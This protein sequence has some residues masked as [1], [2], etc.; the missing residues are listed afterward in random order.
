MRAL[1]GAGW[2]LG[3]ITCQAVLALP[4]PLPHPQPQSTSTPLQVPS[5]H[6]VQR[7]DAKDKKPYR[8]KICPPPTFQQR[9]DQFLETLTP[10]QTSI[11]QKRL[12][13]EKE[14]GK[15]KYGISFYE[16]TYILPFYYTGSP[17]YAVYQGNT[18]EN[19][20]VNHEEVKYQLSF[21]F[22]IWANMFG[23]KVSIGASYTQLSYWQ[24]YTKSSYFRETNYK[25]AIFISD[26]FLPN[27]MVSVGVV[28]ESN[29]RGGVFERNWNRLYCDIVVSGTNWV[30]NI[31]PWILIFRKH[32]SDLD[33]PD[34]AQYLGYG[35]I[36]FAYKFYNQEVSLMFRNTITSGFKRGAIE[37]AYSFPVHGRLIGYV[38][39]FTGYGQSLIEY[40]HYSNSVGVGLAL[41]NWT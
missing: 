25:P 15:S 13:A 40:N 1:R 12:K 10:D 9:L 37:A 22:P 6:Y 35:R 32:S 41:S 7:Y 16:P 30:I 36:V 19:Q 27:W 29:G 24:F 20:R 21:I 18:P 34:I 23:S 4:L 31:K 38:R 26:H 11:L 8:V 17:Y 14:I 33:N 39:F 3:V 28:H 5:C 2:I